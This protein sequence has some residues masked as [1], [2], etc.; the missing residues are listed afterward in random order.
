M[1]KLTAENMQSLGHAQKDMFVSRL[2]KHI[3]QTW[4]EEC[5]IVGHEKLPNLIGYVA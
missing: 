1:I 3:H 5:Q 2:V 4:P